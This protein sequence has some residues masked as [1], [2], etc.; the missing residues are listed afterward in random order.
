MIKIKNLNFSYN[1]KIPYLLES[2]NLDIER[3]SY[4][5]IVGENGSAK[6]TL[7]KLILGLL[8][9]ITGS[10]SLDSNRIS[11]VPQKLESFNSQFPITVY[12]LLKCHLKVLGL[13]DI[14]FISKSLEKVNMK[15]YKNHLLGNLSGGQLQK[16]FIARSLIGSPEILILDEPSTGIDH[17]S[18]IDIY[19]VIKDLNVSSG[20]TVITVEHNIKTVLSN[21]SHIYLLDKGKGRFIDK[22]HYL[23]MYTK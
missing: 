23:D 18:Q 14:S 15:E 19:S 17:Q 11:Y 6:S 12:E 4:V 21:S 8:K 20:V 13:N 10:V 22:K 2:I 5:T 16:V 7:V 1:G 3:G 9:P